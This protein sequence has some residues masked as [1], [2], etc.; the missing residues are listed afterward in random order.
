MFDQWGQG[1][2]GDGTTAQQHWA[3]PL[4]GAEVLGRRGMD[5]VF[6]NQGM[7]PCVGNEFLFSR[8]FPNNVQG[9]FI[10][11][12]VI[13]MNGMP[14]F[15]I[16]DDSAGY[17]GERIM[18]PTKDASGKQMPDDLIVSTDKNFRPV[19]PQIG[20]DGALWFGDWCNAVIGHMQ[21]SQR[22]PDRDH[23]RGRIY[24]M[25]Y[26]KKK[27]LDP[28]TQYGKSELELLDQLRDYEWRTRY[29]AR[30]ELRDRP[31]DKVLAAVNKW[32][33]SLDKHDPE[34]DRLRCE[35][36]W[37]EESQHAVDERLLRQVLTAKTP[38]ALR[39]CNARR[40]QRARV[41]TGSI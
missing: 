2:V 35:A 32:L 4:S 40:K 30:R 15:N 29:H 33:A 11:A 26:T 25:V 27:L 37:A 3:T 38:N 17:S 7:R 24:R 31:K 5:P 18:L 41:P 8:Q 23:T 10:Y 39:C 9:Q 1:F 6:N 22:D 21:Y 36:L 20:P 13:N 34:N 28:V 12:C 16:R 14:R 19:D